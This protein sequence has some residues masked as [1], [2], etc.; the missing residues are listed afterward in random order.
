MSEGADVVSR[1]RR[2]MSGV[3]LVFPYFRTRASTE[4]LFPPL[5]PAAPER[6][7]QAGRRRGARLRL[8]LQLPRGAASTTSSPG[9][10]PIV[11]ISEHGEP[12]RQHAAGRRGAPRAPAGRP[13]GRR[14]AAADR[15]PGPL[16]AARRRSSS[17][18]R[19]TSASPRSAATTSRAGHAGDDLGD[20]PLAT[21]AGLV[22]D[23]GG[24]ARR[25]PAGAPLGGG[26]RRLSPARPR[27]LRPRAPTRRAWRDRPGHRPTSLI[28][29]LGCPYGCE[30]CSKP[31]FG[32]VVRRR[33]LDSGVRGDRGHRPPRL[34]RPVDR[35]RHLHARSPLPRGVL[36]PRRAAAA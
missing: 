25:Q 31:V 5:G 36:P 22:A 30:F 9:G 13:A 29:T 7:P 28:A 11:G 33:A 19:R 32:D 8:H 26:D 2:A 14:R 12:D 18:A 4:M 16:S 27:R 15:V 3:A 10:P 20:L 34:R 1:D 35:R 6:A 21:Y 17:A 24:L 23:G